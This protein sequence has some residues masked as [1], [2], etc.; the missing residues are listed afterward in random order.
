[1][2]ASA[3]DTEITETAEAPIGPW[4]HPRQMLQAEVLRGTADIV[5]APTALDVF[6]N[7][8]SWRP[9]DPQD[10]KVALHD[11]AEGLLRAPWGG[12]SGA[13]WSGS[14]APP[15]SFRGARRASPDRFQR[16]FSRP[17]DSGFDAYASPRNNDG[18]RSSFG[19]MHAAKPPHSE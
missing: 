16:V 18:E 14:L 11:D 10:L 3:L 6:A 5:A 9:H 13:V 17:M 1:M 19:Q 7:S 2:T 15:S 4:R 12:A 8:C